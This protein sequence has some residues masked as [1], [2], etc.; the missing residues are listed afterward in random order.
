MN[1]W[2]KM[3][4]LDIVKE[5]T[6]LLMK[7]ILACAFAIEDPPLVDQIIFGIKSKQPLGS[8]LSI[9]MG[10]VVKRE[11]QPHLVVFPELAE[12]YIT[13][14][15]REIIFNATQVRNYVIDMIQKRKEELDKGIGLDRYDLMT[16]LLQDEIFKD[17][18]E[19]IMD[20]TLTFF[21]A[22]S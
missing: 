12:F 8:S 3:G 7:V 5:S 22:G 10:R 1:D 9:N 18:P 11:L 6:N 17:S 14:T 13:S 21:I 4:E 15:D 2:E 16:I 19:M 20:E